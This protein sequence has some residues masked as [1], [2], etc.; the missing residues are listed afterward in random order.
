MGKG[1]QEGSVKCVSLVAMELA[2]T[3]L[4]YHQR[5]AL[6]SWYIVHSYGMSAVHPLFVYKRH[7]AMFLI[8]Q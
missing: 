4:D 5:G 8:H 6:E 3:T 7:H 2:S 1:G